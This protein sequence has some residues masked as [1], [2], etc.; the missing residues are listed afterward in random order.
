MRENFPVTVTSGHD[1]EQQ[2]QEM[3][4]MFYYLMF[5]DLQQ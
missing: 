2:I 1:I 3:V 5:L 4:M